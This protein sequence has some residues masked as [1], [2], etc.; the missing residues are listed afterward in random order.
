MQSKISKQNSRYL[1]VT[2]L[3]VFV[4]G[5]LYLHMNRNQENFQVT[6]TPTPPCSCR[7]NQNNLINYLWPLHGTLRMVEHCPQEKGD[8]NEDQVCRALGING[9]D[10]P[11]GRVQVLQQWLYEKEAQLATVDT[12][13]NALEEGGYIRR[14][15]LPSHTHSGSG[16]ARSDHTHND[17]ASV[18]HNQPGHYIY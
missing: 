18:D 5:I 4:L 8:H 10:G 6:G 3:V 13:T 9:E 16:S 15:E 12:L 7:E 17:Y 14:D 1:I 11:P 2:L